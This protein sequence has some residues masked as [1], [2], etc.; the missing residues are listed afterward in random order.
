MVGII[1][2]AISMGMVFLLGSVGEIITEKSGHLN[3]GIPGIM[4]LGTAGGCFGVS[5][6]MNA[7][8]SA[9]SAQWIFLII[10]PIVFAMLFAA[11]GGLIYAFLTVT[12]RVNQNVVGLALTTFGAGFAQF[13]IDEFVDTIRFSK[14]S[15]IIRTPLPFADSLGWFGKVFFSYGILVYLSIVIAIVSAIILKKTRVG[16]NLRAVGENP[17][18]AD[19]AG[20]NVAAY[21]YGAILIGSAIAGLGGLVYVMEYNSGTFDNTLTIQSY[22]WL[23]IA[24]VIFTMWKPDLC[25][26]G[27]IVFGALYILPY[28]IVGLNSLGQQELIKLLPYV[29]TI[30]VLIVISILDSKENQP[31]ASLGLNYFREDR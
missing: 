8:N 9:N 19:A 31:P 25:I 20:V 13:F 6:Y 7:L 27:S 2:G 4:C 22:G 24:L 18:T 16:L 10:I 26:L 12:L 1:V 3:L 11:V 21:K 28:K 5:I 29:F 14:A 23:S 15:K 17:A 30:I